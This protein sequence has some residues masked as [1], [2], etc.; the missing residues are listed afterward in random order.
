[1]N[2]LTF[3]HKQSILQQFNLFGTFTTSR[4]FIIILTLNYSTKETRFPD[5]HQTLRERLCLKVNSSN[6]NFAKKAG[7][8]FS[9]TASSFQPMMKFSFPNKS[10]NHSNSNTK[11]IIL[12]QFGLVT[13][14]SSQTLSNE[15]SRIWITRRAF[16][17]N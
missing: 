10:C 13:S 5:F 2:P 4:F 15:T 11:P 3:F 1:M 16:S 6:Q 7:F 17:N 9:H 8:D 14:K 12:N